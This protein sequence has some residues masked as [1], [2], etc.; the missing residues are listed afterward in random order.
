MKSLFPGK[1]LGLVKALEE[2]PA[3]F[4]TLKDPMSKP[5]EACI[6]EFVLNPKN[7]ILPERALSIFKAL[8]EGNVLNGKPPTL[9]EMPIENLKQPVGKDKL[10]FKE[11]INF[12][13]IYPQNSIKNFNS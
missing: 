3:L 13:C 12:G 2:N 10:A 1:A 5:V 9:S 8:N 11:F 4:G 7:K 6:R